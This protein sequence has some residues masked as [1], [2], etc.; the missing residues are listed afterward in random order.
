MN[1]TFGCAA[2]AIALVAITAPAEAKGCIKGALVG[3]AAGHFAGHGHHRGG[4]IRPV[5]PGVR[6]RVRLKAKR[7]VADSAACAGR[8]VPAISMHMARLWRQPRST[9]PGCDGRLLT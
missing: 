5:R 6:V 4:V 7:Q 1:K 3:G 2:I 8:L 9:P